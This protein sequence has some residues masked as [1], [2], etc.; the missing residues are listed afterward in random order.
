M[1]KSFSEKQFSVLFARALDRIA[2]LQSKSKLSLYDEI[3]YALGR[4]GGSAIQ[5]WIYNQKVPA[6]ANEL[7]LLVELINDRQGWQH[8]QE[9]QDFLISGGHP[10]PEQV[11][12]S[13]AESN[14][15]DDQIANLP[16][17]PFVVGPPIFDP[18]KF[19]GRNREVKRVFMALQGASL[20]HCAVIGKHRSGKTSLLH[21]LKKI[22]KT[23]PE[24]LRPEQ[25]QDWLVMPDRFQWVFVDFQ[26]PRM[27]T[28]EGFF[29]YLINQLSFVQPAH[30]NLPSFI[31]TLARRIHTPTVILLDEIQAA[32]ML[33]ELDRQFWWALRSL[34]TNLTE[35]KL[36]F[37][38]TSSK[39]LSELMLDDGQPSPFL[40][41][42]GHVMDLGPFTEEEALE[43]LR[44]SPIQFDEKTMEWMIKTSQR[45]PALLQI[46]CNL[47]YESDLENDLDGWKTTALERLR[48]Y[49]GLLS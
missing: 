15:A 35:G 27:G 31:D 47:Y 6:K 36:S 48:P 9:I 23:V 11:A 20:Q 3:G 38:I 42:F 21:Y 44:Y 14:F 4:S 5:Y 8:W 7:E 37:I 34:G 29:K 45:W 10:N 33:P 49:Q 19:F 41:I 13:Y 16:T 24:A 2:S 40:N 17:T 32:F 46:L 22:T 30:L 18:I 39:P 1:N 25:K 26:D 28:Q 12:K 43:F